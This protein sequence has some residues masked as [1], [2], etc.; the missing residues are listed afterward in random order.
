MSQVKTMAK[1]WRSIDDEHSCLRPIPCLIASFI[2]EDSLYAFRRPQSVFRLARG[3]Y[4]EGPRPLNIIVATGGG[5]GSGSDGVIYA[6][7][8]S[9]GR[10]VVAVVR[11]EDI[12]YLLL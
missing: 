2:Y 1:T 12:F 4:E 5:S 6:T 9:H 3:S 11:G 7:F 8:Y 10:I